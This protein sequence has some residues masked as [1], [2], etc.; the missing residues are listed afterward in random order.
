MLDLGPGHFFECSWACTLSLTVLGCLAEWGKTRGCGCGSQAS[1][2]SELLA[3]TQTSMYLAEPV[4]SSRLCLAM[5]N[6]FPTSI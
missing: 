2:S 1:V 3:R 5:Y 6:W 4:S